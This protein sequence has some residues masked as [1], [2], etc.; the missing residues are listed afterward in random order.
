M[1]ANVI[2]I[3]GNANFRGFHEKLSVARAVVGKK[4][5][6]TSSLGLKCS[7]VPDDYF[8]PSVAAAVNF[9]RASQLKWGS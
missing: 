7:I 2:L 6:V 3:G 8:R 1:A 9:K 4:S 5:S